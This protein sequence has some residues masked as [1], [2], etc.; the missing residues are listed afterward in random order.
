MSSD[1][2]EKLKELQHQR[3]DSSPFENDIEFDRWADNVLPLLAFNPRL[4]R[5]FNSAVA[6]VNVYRQIKSQASMLENINRAIG[7]VNQA[8]TLLEADPVPNAAGNPTANPSNA[9][10]D[11][12]D[13]PLGKIAIGVIVIVLAACALYV[14]RNHLGLAI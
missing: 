8:V 1:L 11:W 13:M 10:K 3:S 14:F 2:L 6:S 12:H 9:V 7:F 4:Q 5:E